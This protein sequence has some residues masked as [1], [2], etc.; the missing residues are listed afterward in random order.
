[1]FF[2]LLYN[3]WKAFPNGIEVWATNG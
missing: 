2:C 3:Y 1:M